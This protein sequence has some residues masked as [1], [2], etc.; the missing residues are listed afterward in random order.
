MADFSSYP[1][2]GFRATSSHVESALIPSAEIST[3]GSDMIGEKGQQNVG[4]TAKSLMYQEVLSSMDRLKEVLEST[5]RKFFYAEN[6]V[7][8]TPVQ[9]A[10][11]I[12][13]A[14]K[15]KLLFMKGEE[16]LK[17]SSS[18]LAGKWSGTGGGTLIRT[19]THPL[20]G[21]LWLKQS[22]NRVGTVIYLS[23]LGLDTVE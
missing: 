21:M 19:G 22:R 5:D 9:K 10:A 20:T 2:N 6:F 8:A 4:A 13:R 18:P 3:T 1:I 12:I 15:S 17:G 11:E 14:K 7:Y 16:S 23:G